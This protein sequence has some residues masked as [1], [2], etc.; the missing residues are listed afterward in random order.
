MTPVKDDYYD[1]SQEA[2]ILHLLD[3]VQSSIR[4]SKF[5]NHSNEK[6]K[7]YEGRWRE[8][9]K[10][11][12]DPWREKEQYE[13]FF[14]MPY[15][16]IKH[17]ELEKNEYILKAYSFL[18][19]ME[20][21]GIPLKLSG[22]TFSNDAT[23]KALESIAD[24]SPKLALI[25]LIRTGNN[26][27]LDALFSIKALTKIDQEYADRMS[28]EFLDVLKKSFTEFKDGNVFFSKNLAI[29]L[30]IILPQI[31]A[32][33]C[34]KNSYDVKK[35][36][37]IFL[38]DYVYSFEKKGSYGD[39]SIL[40]KSIITSFSNKEL[41]QLFP[42]FLEFPIIPD[43]YIDKHPDPFEWIS[44]EN[45]GKI[46]DKVDANLINK[47]LKASV[48]NAKTSSNI[49]KKYLTR[50]VV[51]WRYR[52]LTDKQ[53]EIFA[54]LL[55]K[56]RR[57][58][59]F[60][61]DM[62]SEEF[63]FLWFPYPK[64]LDSTPLQ[65][66]KKYI[67]Q[68]DIY[69]GKDSSQREGI[70]ITHG[71]SSVITNI[72]EPF[73]CDEISYEWNDSHLN[74]LLIKILNWWKCDKKYL[75]EN[76][77]DSYVFSIKDEFKARFSKMINLFVYIFAPNI[78]LIDG[79]YTESIAVLLKEL[80]NYKMNDLAA[81]AA[82]IEIFPNDKDEIFSSIKNALLSQNEEIMKD[83]ISA[84]EAFIRQNNKQLTAFVSIISQ[85]I[86]YRAGTNLN[87]ILDIATAMV[88][89]CP[90]YLEQPIIDEINI[91]L[92][93]MLKELEIC[94]ED[95][96]ENIRKKNSYC[97]S[98]IKLVFALKKYFNANKFEMP[99]Y[100]KYWKEH[101][102]NKNEF[103]AIRNTWINNELAEAI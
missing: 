100:V 45:I 68:T 3:Y 29:N 90:Q 7:E 101:C 55:W 16:Q 27:N 18:K 39:V 52:Q 95:D 32:R 62:D 49:R 87:Q 54:D 102:L 46:E 81:R 10:Y 26:R 4:Y 93:Y 12:C 86:K 99:T 15:Q 78:E 1:I 74:N 60:P 9:I 98:G 76:E 63:K 44:I 72:L 14:K 88:K 69:F 53:A 97:I 83:A 67:D 34:C 51:L 30:A 48:Y 28:E 36:I 77:N 84:I 73:I 42:V 89:I 70:E 50:L 57:E 43:I 23:I 19:Y 65:L 17:M 94:N 91:G 47:L 61:A 20:E 33:L 11:E 92:K 24:Y 80:H 64:T 6:R 38:K 103:S 79:K 35:K 85:K 31:L 40:M 66:L 82:F 58:N 71:N 2:Y 41:Q 22:I 75:L 21:I 8:I 96:E 13:T 5:T 37:L 59:G 56:R 25:T